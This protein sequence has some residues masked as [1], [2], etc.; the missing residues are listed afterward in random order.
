MGPISLFPGLII[1]QSLEGIVINQEE[2]Y[3]KTLLA[4]FGM[5]GDSKFQANPCEPHMIV[6][7]NIFRYLKRTTSL[8]IWYPSNSGFFVQVYSNADFG[9]CG[10]DRKRTSGG[11]QF[12]D[13][14]LFSWQSKKQTCVSLSTAEAEYNAIASCTSKVV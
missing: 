11:C 4:K 5:V 9:G 12:Q 13:G 1:R 3:T 10:L 14:K 6:V 7:M 2:A 8:G